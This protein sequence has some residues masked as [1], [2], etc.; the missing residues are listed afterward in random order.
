M[1]AKVQ[2]S[3]GCKSI[4]SVFLKPPPSYLFYTLIKLLCACAY[5]YMCV[6]VYLC[7]CACT[8]VC[9]CVCVYVP[10]C[11][12]ACMCVHIHMLTYVT[13]QMGKLEDSL[14]CNFSPFAMW[15]PGIHFRSSDLL[16]SASTY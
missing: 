1:S 8:N 12:C 10:A 13:V 3:V 4:L 7:V 5:V 9:M 16:A 15:I 2:T 14:A 11:I 6:C